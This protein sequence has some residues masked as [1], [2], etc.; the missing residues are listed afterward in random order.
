MVKSIVQQGLQHSLFIG[1]IFTGVGTTYLCAGPS[2]EFLLQIHKTARLGTCCT[3]RDWLEPVWAMESISHPG[4]EGPGRKTILALGNRIC[5]QTELVIRV[6]SPSSRW[7]DF[8]TTPRKPRSWT[9]AQRYPSFTPHQDQC[10]QVGLG[11][12]RWGTCQL[13]AHQGWVFRARF[14]QHLAMPMGKTKHHRW[15]TAWNQTLHSAAE[16]QQTG[17]S[18]KTVFCCCLVASWRSLVRP[19]KEKPMSATSLGLLGMFTP[20]TLWPLRKSSH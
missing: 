10:L 7:G 5:W 2:S 4:R 9:A 14:H 18:S 6:D 3:R 8:P 20:P 16:L 19:G 11:T 17:P 13:R 15:W 1:I 12:Q